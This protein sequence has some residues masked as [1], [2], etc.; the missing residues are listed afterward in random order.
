[1][2][3]EQV[4]RQ[5][6][7]RLSLVSETAQLDAQLLLAHIMSVST[8][9]FYTWPD[10]DVADQQLREFEQL[11]VRREQGEPI[12]YIVGEQ[13]FWDLTL[14][15]SPCTLIPRADTER[16]V[17]V[18]LDKLATLKAPRIL[19]LGTGTGAIA[20]ALA[21]ELNQATV[22]G[23]DFQE[24]AV[25][26]AQRNAQRNAIDNA[27]FRQSDWF[28]GVEEQ[29]RFDVIV[30][31]PPY[32]DPEDAHLNQGDVRFEPLSALVAQ[33]HGLADI[34]HI[35]ANAQTHLVEGGWLMFEHGYDQG[36]A[37]RSLLVA[38][39]YQEVETFQDFGRN[40]RVTIGRKA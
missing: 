23:I 28:S 39:C 22:M 5:A 10:K 3:I 7:Q 11:L 12:A 25:A 21:H 40:D 27:A 18:A 4:L 2:I 8:T 19:D 31:N 26:L 33:D 24:S 9:H 32:I 6:A 36:A 13:G 1:M 20:L 16:L 15:T 37:V 14:E 30:S 29:Q 38:A 17:E 34:R 35:V